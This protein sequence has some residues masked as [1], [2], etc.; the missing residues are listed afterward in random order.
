MV[1]LSIPLL[2]FMLVEKLLR[3]VESSWSWWLSAYLEGRALARHR[4][5]DLIYSTGGA[6][7]AHV[8]G[9]A[10]KQALG[11]RWLA[12]VHDPL[13]MPGSTPKTAQERMQAEVERQICTDADVAIWFTEQALASAKRRHPQLGE[14]GKMLLPGID[15][16]FKVLPP[17]VQGP[18][19]VIGHFGSL[20]ATRNL[21]PILSALESLVA[22]RPEL[23]S[24]LELQLTGGPLDAVSQAAI[25]QSPVRDLVRHLGRIEAD[26]AT[27]LSGREQILRRMRS[28]D[29][30]LLLLLHGTEPI[31][32]EYI[33][34]K[35][36]E[37]LWMQRPILATVHGNV[38]MAGLLRGQGHIAVE[39]DG[40]LMVQRDM[41]VTLMML[42]E[43]WSH[44][45]LQDNARE[46]RF[47]TRAAVAS[48]MEWL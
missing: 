14:R 19:M 46:S 41:V 3:P 24:M 21:T 47:T 6:F 31:C 30:L 42:F 33:P 34:S 10:L 44:S 15:A 39:M 2:P 48:L 35:L 4:K 32:A 9:R 12:E 20:S 16:P 1:L 28:A 23:R 18:K 27:G 25:A 37:Y 40:D 26:P 36:Y 45:G 38:Q 13:V 22:R 11:V 29:V 7:A 8:A 43:R 5:F 17:Y